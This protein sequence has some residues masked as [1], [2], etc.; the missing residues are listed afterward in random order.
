MLFY[1]VF[2]TFNRK[3][4][5]L[6]ALKSLNPEGP[7]GSYLCN[8]SHSFNHMLVSFL[9]NKENKQDFLLGDKRSKFLS[10][11]LVYFLVPVFFL[12]LSHSFSRK[13]L[14]LLLNRFS[15]FFIVF[16]CFL[17]L[18]VVLRHAFS[19][20]LYL[21]TQLSCS[22]QKSCIPIQICYLFCLFQVIY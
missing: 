6:V 11:S 5:S 9:W 16:N 19:R 3:N 14:L 22:F 10:F 13:I 4:D 17:L 1:S 20:F 12:F 18:I 15:I 8:S 7:L 21:L 2:H